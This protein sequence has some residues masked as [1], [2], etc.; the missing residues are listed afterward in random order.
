MDFAAGI[1]GPTK[2]EFMNAIENIGSNGG[3]INK[4]RIIGHGGYN[5]LVDRNDDAFIVFEKD[6]IQGDHEI[7]VRRP[8]ET[9]VRIDDDL[10]RITNNNSHILLGGCN[11]KQL[12]KDI[13]MLLDNGAKVTG[14]ELGSIEIPYT[15]THLGVPITYW[16]DNGRLQWSWRTE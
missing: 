4:L 6:T 14:Y 8:D 9:N 1:T 15:D 2:T 16:S 10:R 13:A 3:L 7:N 12:A 5:I 11:T